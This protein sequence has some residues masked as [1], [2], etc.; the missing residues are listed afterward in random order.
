MQAG[1]PIQSLAF[2]I[3]SAVQHDLA[4]IVQPEYRFDRDKNGQS[5]KEPTGKTVEHRP[6]ED[7]CEA[8]HF[9]QVWGDTSL[10][11]GGMAGQSVTM[12]YTTVVTG[13]EGDAC[14]Y[15]AGR[16]AYRVGH[17]NDAFHEDLSKHSMAAVNRAVRY[18][19]KAKS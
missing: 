12:A 15:F 6:R 3:V 5:R 19:R 16:F 9:P 1:N 18:E 2:A 7:M 11:F 17:P 10:G 14:V 8:F 13:P 4:P